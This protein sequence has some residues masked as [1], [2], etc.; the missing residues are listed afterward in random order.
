MNTKHFK[1]INGKVL[2]KLQ[3]VGTY[4]RESDNGIRITDVRG[5]NILYENMGMA[6][7]HFIS[8]NWST[9]ITPSQTNSRTGMQVKNKHMRKR[10]AL[11]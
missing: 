11:T 3:Q 1:F 10:F 9:R 8:F 6:V 2:F 5:K 7:G 4:E